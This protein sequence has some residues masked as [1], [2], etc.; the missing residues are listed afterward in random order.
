MEKNHRIDIGKRPR[1]MERLTRKQ[2]SAIPRA[3]AGMLPVKA[4]QKRQ[5]KEDLIFRFCKQQ[6]E[7][8]FFFRN[9]TVEYQAPRSFLPEASFGL[10]IL[11]SPASVFLSVCLCVCINHLLVRTITHQPFTLESP[12]L[13][14]R[15]KTPWLRCLLF[16]GVID[17]DL[18]F[19]LVRTITFR[20]FKLESPNL[21]QKCILVR[22]R[23]LLFWGL[24]DLDL[25]CQI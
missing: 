25:Q 13:D 17:L 15:R 3:R 8:F 24:I 4:N 21:D 12:N 19:E 22:L 18:H 10:R 5:H 20:S 9:I 1:Y 11:S 14:E 6:E 23:S 7:T 16:L 2:C